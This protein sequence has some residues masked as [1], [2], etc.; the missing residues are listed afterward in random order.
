MILLYYN[1]PVSM[2]QEAPKVRDT[3][4]REFSDE[5]RDAR[6]PPGWYLLPS[7]AAVV[8]ATTAVVL[9]A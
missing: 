9:F 4:E 8:F 2:K 3:I 1:R 5:L 7:F 6:F